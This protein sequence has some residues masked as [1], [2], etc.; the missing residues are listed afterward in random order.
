MKTKLLLLF[1]LLP[2]FTFAQNSWIQKANFG[3]AKRKNAIGFSI[4]SKGYI[5]TGISSS[6]YSYSDFWEYNP[7]TNS[8]TQK[9][10]FGGGARNS[11]VGFSI[12]TNGYVG[13][14]E[15][16]NLYSCFRDFWEYNPSTN[17]WSQK[18]DLGGG[19][20][21]SAVGFSIGSKGYIGTGSYN[22]YGTPVY[23]SSLWEYNPST[24][25]WTQKSP[26]GGGY[27]AGSV[28]F[29]IGSMGYIGTGVDNNGY[30]HDDFWEYDPT[31]DIWT[32]KTDFAGSTK[33]GAVGFSIGT[34]GYIGTGYNGT[35]STYLDDFYE[36]DQ[37]TNVW[38]N[39]DY[40]I[41]GERGDAVGFAIGNIGY[42]GTGY[43]NGSPWYYKD[44]WKY[45]PSSSSGINDPQAKSPINI[46]PNPS[47]GEFSITLESKQSSVNK[48]DFEVYNV[49]G[50]KVYQ[51]EITNP[52]SKIDLSNQPNGIYFL[53]LK[54][55]NGAA[56]QKLI[57]LK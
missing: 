49:E 3:G 21:R 23:Y 26:F 45:I 41:G 9:A 36:W 50:K 17:M 11:A 10:D 29:A 42:I 14:G 43:V 40:F 56:T 28:G 13:T 5:G 2:C 19:V 8:W 47:S 20:R 1:F 55:E 27:R 15:D 31:I 34:K 25:T 53:Y 39:T 38:I 48:I 30:T 4:G 44:F 24:D 52:Q 51:S 33:S 46:F 57:I 54:S 6:D 12:G 32:Q 22:D 35:N 16:D 7:S 37:G 18:A